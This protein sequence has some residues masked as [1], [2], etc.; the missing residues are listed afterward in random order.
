NGDGRTDVRDLVLMT[1]CFQH[2]LDP[3]DSV[4][5]C[6]DCTGDSRFSFDDLF[7]CTRH[8]LRGPFVP[9]DSVHGAEQPGVAFET[10]GAAGG[11]VVVRARLTGPRSLSAAMVRLAYPA[12]RWQA[13]QPI[14]IDRP[15][16]ADSFAGWLP[17]VDVDEPGSVHLGG[18]RLGD[19]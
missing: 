2:V 17:F 1:R 11:N 12:D 7:C 14:L 3:A 16:G 15:T 10:V 4:R 19:P 9:R 13:S 6:A 8:I 18:V 5:I